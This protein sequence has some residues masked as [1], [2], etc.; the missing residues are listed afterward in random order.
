MHKILNGYMLRSLCLAAKFYA[1]KNENLIFFRRLRLHPKTFRHFMIIRLF[2]RIR[3]IYFCEQNFDYN[4]M[5]IILWEQFSLVLPFVHKVC[6]GARD[7]KERWKMSAEEKEIN[8]NFLNILSSF[9]SVECVSESSS[10]L[11]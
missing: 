2:I 4:C 10:K 11:L 6:Q 3:N 8:V 5:I 7:E 1:A 9:A